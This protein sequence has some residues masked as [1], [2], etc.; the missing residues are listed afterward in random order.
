MSA[1]GALMEI[2][3]EKDF[4][5]KLLATLQLD[6]YFYEFEYVDRGTTERGSFCSVFI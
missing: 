1:N 4:L 2:M 6:S 5:I 3:A